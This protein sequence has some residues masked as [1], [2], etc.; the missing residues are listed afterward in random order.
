[1]D[2]LQQTTACMQKQVPHC[3][4]LV[5]LKASPD[6]KRQKVATGGWLCIPLVALSVVLPALVFPPSMGADI[7]TGTDPGFEGATLAVVPP[8]MG[9][10][11]SWIVT[12][13]A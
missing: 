5:T 9:I 2:H 8:H 11:L 1:M 3:H 6:I 13:C 12:R 10:R 4:A 7:G